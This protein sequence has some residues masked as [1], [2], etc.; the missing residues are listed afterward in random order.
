[1]VLASRLKLVLGAR[2]LAC[3]FVFEYGG[4]ML[5]IWQYGVRWMRYY[6]DRFRSLAIVFF[7]GMTSTEN[8]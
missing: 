3:L 5:G 7:D 4:C 1:M 2:L 6:R 8:V